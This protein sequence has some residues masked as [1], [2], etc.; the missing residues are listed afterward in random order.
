MNVQIPNHLRHPRSKMMPLS[1]RSHRGRLHGA[2]T[3]RGQGHPEVHEGNDG[4]VQRAEETAQKV[5]LSGTDGVAHI[6]KR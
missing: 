1:C 3:G 6:E 5:R 4:L 2:Q